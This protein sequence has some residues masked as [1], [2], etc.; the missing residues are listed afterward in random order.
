[1]YCLFVYLRFEFDIDIVSSKIKRATRA[2]W[3]AGREAQ[4]AKGELNVEMANPPTKTRG[5]IVED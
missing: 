3:K 5:A 1:M 2:I 4:K